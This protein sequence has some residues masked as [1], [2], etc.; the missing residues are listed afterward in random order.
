MRQGL[1]GEATAHVADQD[2]VCGSCC[3]E[4]SVCFVF[5]D[6]QKSRSPKP[7]APDPNPKPQTIMSGFLTLAAIS[8]H[9]PSS[10]LPVKSRILASPLSH[11]QSPV[12]TNSFSKDKL[13]FGAGR[14]LA[15]SSWSS[16][17]GPAVRQ[18]S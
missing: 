6:F 18:C 16:P 12:K 17:M 5:G 3:L 13:Q 11:G 4:R 7:L 15:R 10:V 2:Q 8:C 14:P 9:S 1:I